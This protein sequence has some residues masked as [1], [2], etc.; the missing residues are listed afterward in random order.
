MSKTQDSG[1]PVDRPKYRIFFVEGLPRWC[2]IEEVKLDDVDHAPACPRC[3]CEHVQFKKDI[4]QHGF[5]ED[6]VTSLGKCIN[7]HWI[8][9]HITIGKMIPIGGE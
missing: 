4:I 7:Q 1:A 5:W 8:A 9:Y 6:D 2:R 3:G